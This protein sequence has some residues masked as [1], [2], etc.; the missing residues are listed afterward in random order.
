MPMAFQVVNRAGR[1]ELSKPGRLRGRMNMYTDDAFGVCLARDLD[2]D[3]ATVR[4][5]FTALLGDLACRD[6]V[7]AQRLR[8]FSL[9]TIPT[10]YCH[11][12]ACSLFSLFYLQNA[13]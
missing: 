9:P 1:W 2:N 4:F 12:S 10:L 5:F 8:A 7:V 6:T 3:M 11:F 13:Q